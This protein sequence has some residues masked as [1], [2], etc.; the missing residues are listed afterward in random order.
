M[1]CPLTH[2]HTQYKVLDVMGT[3][4]SEFELNRLQII[5]PYMNRD[6]E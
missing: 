6:V 1:E 3:C 4:G 2:V 5:F